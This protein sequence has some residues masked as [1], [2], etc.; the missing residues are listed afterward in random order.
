MKTEHCSVY[1]TTQEKRC[2]HMRT[3]YVTVKCFKAFHVRFWHCLGKS[4]LKQLHVYVCISSFV[5][6]LVLFSSCR[7]HFK[8]IYVK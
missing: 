4:V 7:F 2:I 5:V 6:L 3:N 8:L 1:E